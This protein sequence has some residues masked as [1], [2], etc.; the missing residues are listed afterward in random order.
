[1]NGTSPSV[2]NT[3]PGPQANVATTRPAAGI[4]RRARMFS[5]LSR[6]VVV[7]TFAVGL[8]TWHGVSQGPN[9]SLAGGLSA[10]R[11]VAAAATPDTT[12][13]AASETKTGVEAAR[14]EV[15]GQT[16]VDAAAEVDGALSQSMVELANRDR[17]RSRLKRYVRT[18]ELDVAAAAYAATLTSGRLVHATNLDAGLSGNWSKL[19]ENLG[20]GRDVLSIH[21]ALMASPTHRA[22]I[23]DTGFTQ[24]GV[25]VIRTDAGLVMVQ[26]FRQG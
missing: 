3:Q 21:Q 17:A 25:A 5:L 14:L 10:G 4:R 12:S 24:I 18:K 7:S 19:G 2:P 13:T 22:N 11:D 16:E 20:R 8:T 26:R 9:Q 1:V 23:L 6:Y 15:L